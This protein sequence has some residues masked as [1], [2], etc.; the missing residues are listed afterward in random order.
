MSKYSLCYKKDGYFFPIYLNRLPF[1]ENKDELDLKTIDEFIMLFQN[2]GELIDYLL[3]NNKY[4]YGDDLVIC[5]KV[6]DSKYDSYIPIY[7]GDKLFFKKDNC[8][9]DIDF[10]EKY[11]KAN[12]DDFDFIEKLAD[13]YLE[14]YS[15]MKQNKNV[16]LIP[17]KLASEIKKYIK[18]G[19]SVL[20]SKCKKEI[21]LLISSEL[22]NGS[23][24]SDKLE[25]TK[26]IINS[27]PIIKY[28][29]F[30]VL[31]NLI[32]DYEIE[33]QLNECL[34]TRIYDKDI[35]G[36]QDETLTFEDWIPYINTNLPLEDVYSLIDYS[37]KYSMNKRV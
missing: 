9:V 33:K 27:H 13:N 32:K 17:Y 22:Y 37:K 19:N 35:I 30:R 18:S 6:R 29:N 2:K 15:V 12:I 28:K 25:Y 24:E 31:I 26:K 20:D 10:I 23:F 34:E 3:E 7:Q 36:T 8:L 1:F 21:E 4:V 11:I 14:K 16:V 5:K